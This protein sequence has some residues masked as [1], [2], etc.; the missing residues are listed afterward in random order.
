MAVLTAA[1]CLALICC[2][3][4]RKPVVSNPTNSTVITKTTDC[5]L[6][7]DDVQSTLGAKVNFI[8]KSDFRLGLAESE[9]ADPNENACGYSNSE[10]AYIY[11]QSRAMADPAAA[12]KLYRA[13]NE[14][15]SQLIRNE[16]PFYEEDD[17]LAIVDGGFMTRGYNSYAS[18]V[19]ISGRVEK[20]AFQIRSSSPKANKISY[21]ILKGIAVRLSRRLP[22]TPS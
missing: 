8:A 7:E 6:T 18:L 16:S 1:G 10:G 5:A 21:V 19:N 17:I 22:T 4:T 12:E 11:W 14:K 15:F 3:S 9:K 20:I 13:T 2:T